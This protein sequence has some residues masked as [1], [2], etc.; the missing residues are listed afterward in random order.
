MNVGG[1]DGTVTYLLGKET[2]VEIEGPN[3]KLPVKYKGSIDGGKANL[4]TSRSFTGAM[5]EV[6]MT[7]KDVWSLSSDGKTLTVERENTT[8]RGTNA[9]TLVFTKK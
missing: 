4:L 3:G 2:T 9:S 6:T 8:P 7:T 1:G 5:G